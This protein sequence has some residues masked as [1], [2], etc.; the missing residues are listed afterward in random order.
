MMTS[1]SETNRPLTE[2]ERIRF[3]NAII[4]ERYGEWATRKGEQIQDNQDS[5]E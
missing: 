2:E 5:S 4:R 1:D 3:L